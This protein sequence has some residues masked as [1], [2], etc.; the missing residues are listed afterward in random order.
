MTK[1]NRSCSVFNCDRRYGNVCCADC[2]NRCQNRC[3]NSPD[4]CKL[5]ADAKPKRQKKQ[6]EETEN[7]CT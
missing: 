6:T 3:M 7:S 1:L 5:L 2:K 4:K